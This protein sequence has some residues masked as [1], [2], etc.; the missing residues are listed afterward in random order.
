MKEKEIIEKQK[1]LIHHYEE[2]LNRTLA[3]LHVHN[4]SCSA[5]AS[6]K[7]NRLKSELTSLEAEQPKDKAAILKD[8][9]EMTVKHT[10]DLFLLLGLKRYIESMIINDATGD[11]YIFLFM[12]KKEWIDRKEEYASYEILKFVKWNFD[13]RGECPDEITAFNYMVNIRK[14]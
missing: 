11:E 7:G 9:I 13:E 8:F 5:E 14:L 3:Y 1:E 4:A 12:T 6:E 2:E 10:L